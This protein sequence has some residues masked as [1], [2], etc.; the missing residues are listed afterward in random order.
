MHTK[1]LDQHWF[2]T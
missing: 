1:K 2:Q